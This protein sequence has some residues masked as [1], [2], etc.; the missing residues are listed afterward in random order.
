MSEVDK[1]IAFDFASTGIRALAAEVL[2]NN[3][4]RI[5]AF[6]KKKAEGIKNGIIEQPSGT[7]FNVGTLWK[8]INNSSG[9][10]EKFKKFSTSFGGKN[11]K[12]V[13]KTI[14]KRLN[15]LKP[16]TEEIINNMA[17][18]C[19]KSFNQEDMC[20]YDTIPVMYEVDHEEFEKPEGRKGNYILGTY[21]LVVGSSLMKTQLDKCMER[22]AS[23][24]AEFMPLS[25]DAFSIAV[26]EENERME[27][28]AVINLGETSTTLAVYKNEMLQHLM[29]V[30]LGGKHLT[31]DIEEIGISESNAERLKCAKGFACEKYVDLPINIKIPSVKTGAE[32]VV[33]TNLF[34]SMIIE[35]RLDEIMKPVFRFL[36]ENKNNLPHGLI[37][38]G[39]GSRLKS[40]REYFEEKSGVMTRYG[41]H[42]GWLTSD[43][44]SEYNKPE[45]SQ[46]I[47]TILLTHEYR[48]E[49]VKPVE[50]V[51]SG[52]K[53]KSGRR[54]I[55][56]T[57]TQGFIR[58]F[59]E[60]TEIQ[61][62]NG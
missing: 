38:T 62:S 49:N 61:E 23:C 39:G 1:I 44:P 43:T 29:V 19:E 40:I 41:D 16:I 17:L 3:S 51:V 22:V 47:G 18:E 11:M 34:V 24:D 7:A 15:K 35:A 52:T 8:E 46:L 54:S 2:P 20:V 14:E 5:K 6:E 55:R 53:K 48:Q 26:T 25:A 57:F 56:E 33:V 13:I 59:E 36:K 42:T 28:C 45:Y 21:Y 27:G 37:L 30:P 4:V 50:T 32:P 10:H 58:F 31:K 12:I 60:D 9:F